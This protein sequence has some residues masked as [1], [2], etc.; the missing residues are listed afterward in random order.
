MSTIL[1]RSASDSY[2]KT[3]PSSFVRRHAQ[4]SSPV[5]PDQQRFFVPALACKAGSPFRQRAVGREH[6]PLVSAPGRT[7]E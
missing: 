1:Y 2:Q 4:S 5:G 7:A 6:L 3:T